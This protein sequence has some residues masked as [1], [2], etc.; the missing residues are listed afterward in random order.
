MA[1]YSSRHPYPSNQNNQVKAE[2]QWNNWFTVIKI[3][4]EKFV[5]DERNRQEATNKP[6]TEKMTN[7]INVASESEQANDTGSERKNELCKQERQTIKG[8]IASICNQASSEKMYSSSDSDMCDNSTIEFADKPPIKTPIC[9]S[10]NQVEL[11][12][13]IGNYTFAAQIE[14]DDFLQKIIN[15]LKKPNATKINRLPPMA[16]KIQVLQPR[17]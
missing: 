9:Y 7:E 13:N 1:D 10:I 3:D 15:L 5:L 6:I 17:H 8:I 14:A 4:Y 16:R 11:L 12:Q 2:E